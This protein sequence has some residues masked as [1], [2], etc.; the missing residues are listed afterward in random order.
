MN[1]WRAALNE[2]VISSPERRAIADDQLGL[3][4]LDVERILNRLSTVPLNWSKPL[5]I[6]G[7]RSNHTVLTMLWTLMSDG[8]G[9]IVERQQLATTL[10]RLVGLISSHNLMIHEADI[11]GFEGLL[12]DL[13]YDLGQVASLDA[14]QPNPILGRPM[15]LSQNEVG[16][17]KRCPTECGWMLMTSGSTMSPKLVMIERQ[18]LVARALGEV[19]DFELNQR[20]T[21]LNVLPA[22]HDVGFNQ[23][24][25]WILSGAQ[26]VVQGHPSTERFKENLRSNHI[27][28][29]SGTPMMWN[30]FLAKTAGDERF[31][32]LRYLAISGG[33]LPLKEIEKL[34]L[35]FPNATI[36]RTYG[37]TE[38]FRSL[39]VKSPP[40]SEI[41]ETHGLPLPDVRLKIR[42][43]SGGYTEAGCEG[44]L[45]HEGVGAM[46]G[47]FPSALICREIGTGDY[48]QRTQ[49]G[50]YKYMGRRDDLIKRWDIRMH[51]S[52]IEEAILAFPD[53]LQACVLSRP[54]GDVRQNAL[55]A[56]VVTNAN[57]AGDASK[58]ESTLLEYCKR[59]LSPSKVP[60]FIFIEDS[61]PETATCKL[62]RQA[63]RRIWEGK[64]AQ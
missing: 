52:E 29:V 36:V 59:V 49:N 44:E 38:T 55:A 10:P 2:W 27:T 9:L 43:E 62:D 50:E 18:D 61:L 35:A 5:V 37:Q 8:L 22:S 57:S 30:S 32:E 60:D 47:Y 40:G 42:G 33:V 15:I 63:L 58:V 56:F 16:S 54:T 7:Q 53:V 25:S 28:G 48:F 11:K 51:L 24:L 46:L 31:P 19:R 21:V 1:R 64:G 12:L 6:A 17:A 34:R 13:G 4:W 26:I 14:F 3:R 23:I 41:Q 20:D 39:I 45:I